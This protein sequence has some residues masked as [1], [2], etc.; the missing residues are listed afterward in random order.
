MS[1]QGAE[2]ENGRLFV[3]GIPSDDLVRWGETNGLIKRP[4]KEMFDR[5]GKPISKH[6]KVAAAKGVE[7]SC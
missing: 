3:D 6:L 7:A 4:L 5:S 2:W 1:K